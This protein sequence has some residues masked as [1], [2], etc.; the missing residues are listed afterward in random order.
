MTPPAVS[1]GA[2]LPTL[3]VLIAG[4]VVLLLD[5]LPPRRSKTHLGGVAL[6]GIVG[7]LLAVVARWGTETRAFRDMVLLDTYALYFD[8]VICY[9]AA[10][11]VMLSMDYLGRT[12]SAC[13]CSPP[14]A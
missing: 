6:A 2:L 5:V 13:C 8:L 4:A 11:I 1:L 14:P 12:D 3:I 7:A 10:L 9:G